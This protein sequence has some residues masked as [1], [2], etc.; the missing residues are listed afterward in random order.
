MIATNDKTLWHS[1]QV[2]RHI[3]PAQQA[4]CTWDTNADIRVQTDNP[5]FLALYRFI[6]TAAH[7]PYDS[8]LAN[9]IIAHKYR[10][11]R[12]SDRLLH[13]NQQ[14]QY[15]EQRRP[16][17]LN[18]LAY[19]NELTGR[20]NTNQKPDHIIYN[21]FCACWL[22]IV[23]LDTGTTIQNYSGKRVSNRWHFNARPVFAIRFLVLGIETVGEALLWFFS[24]LTIPFLCEC[25]RNW[26]SMLL[27]FRW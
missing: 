7:G 27:T 23:C 24:L 21:W 11:T 22:G 17:R 9:K 1:L 3:L 20:L 8:T 6:Q 18:L 25:G 26:K 10:A 16:T 19:R 4:R 15:I 14:H 5:T 13:F 2:F 12:T